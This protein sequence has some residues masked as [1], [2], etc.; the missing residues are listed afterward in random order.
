MSVRQCFTLFSYFTESFVSWFHIFLFQHCFCRSASKS[1]P[2]F[3]CYITGGMRLGEQDPAN[4]IIKCVSLSLVNRLDSLQSPSFSVIIA[5]TYNHYDPF[6]CVMTQ[7]RPRCPMCRALLT[8]LYLPLS[9]VSRSCF[10]IF[11]DS[12]RCL[13]LYIVI[14]CFGWSK[15]LLLT[16]YRVLRGPYN[17]LFFS[18]FRPCCSHINTSFSILSD[19]EVSFGILLRF[20]LPSSSQQS[21]YHRSLV[22]EVFLK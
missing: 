3:S 13:V 14:P 1:R 20:P 6:S 10:Y 9:Q 4:C 17:M 12:L 11:Y 7:H 19:H 18:L 16:S 8:F 5:T 2:V 15:C 21:N 22:S